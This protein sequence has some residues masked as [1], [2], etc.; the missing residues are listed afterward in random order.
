MPTGK[1]K[2]LKYSQGSKSLKV[3][4]VY[5]CDIESLI[6][7]IDAC[8]NNPEQS[9]TTNIS[10]HKTCGFS[11]VTKS[12]VTDIR[13][14]NTFYRNEDCMEKYCKKLKG[15]VMK[16]VNYEMREMI[17]LTRDENEYH[18]KQNKCFICDNGFCYDK[19]N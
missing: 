9:F 17:P 4:A 8:Y 6:Q 15:W 13:E 10:K 11:I 14:K 16:I 12:P 18:G 7:K 2:I 19:K 1:N 3:P 5:Y